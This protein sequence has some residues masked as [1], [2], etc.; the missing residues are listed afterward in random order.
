MTKLTFPDSA[1]S[2]YCAS[3]TFQPRCPHNEV[4]VVI[5]ALYGRM[6]I[7]RCVQTDLGF[8]GCAMDVLSLTDQRCS[9]LQTCQ[10]RLPD[11]IF[12]QTTPCFHELKTYL[13]VSYRCIPGRQRSAYALYMYSIQNSQYVR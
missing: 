9:G 5:S 3:E 12:D 7:G 6:R 10:I 11:Q 13:E 4:V 2:E 8:L 1:V